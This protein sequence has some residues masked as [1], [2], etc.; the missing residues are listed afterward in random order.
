MGRTRYYGLAILLTLVATSAQAQ[1]LGNNRL[2]MNQ[3][4][5]GMIGEP[6][7][8]YFNDTTLNAFLNYAQR[9]TKLALGVSTQFALDTIETLPGQISYALNTDAVSGRVGIV[10]HRLPEALGSME[11]ALQFVPPEVLG[12]AGDAAP[13]ASY[14]IVGQ[15]IFLSKSPD[16]DDTLFIYYSSVP[17]DL[18]ADDSTLYV[19]EEDETGIVL[20]AACWAAY[21][22]NDTQRAQMFYGMWRDFLALKGVQFPQGEAV[23]R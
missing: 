7:A 18:L 4:L 17:T 14:S 10:I 5:R 22:A 21:A 19:A 2:G 12:R 8:T 9:E 20:L 11:A 1:G 6:G 16:G 3:L 23:V 15:N 13:G